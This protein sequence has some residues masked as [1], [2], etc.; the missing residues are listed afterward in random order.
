MNETRGEVVRALAAEMFGTFALV[1]AGTGAIVVNARTGGTLGSVGIA[2]TF[3]FVIMAMIYATGHIS[4]AHFNPAVT[5]GFAI[6]RQFPIWLVLPYWGAQVLGAV[7]GSLAVYFLIGSEGG[8]GTTHPANGVVP[9]LLLEGL[10]TLILMFV[11]MAVAT[12]TRAIGE[13]AAIA[14][15]GT[16]AL[17]ALFAGAITGASMNPARSLGPA[18][19][20]N[21]FSDLALYI[22]GP[23]FG[24]LLGSALYR[25]MGAHPKS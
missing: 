22:I 23:I 19:V 14:I 11:I 2:L 17:E 15:G 21:N 25:W 18:L 12:D 24:A 5:L 16:I 13:A 9:A 6:A 10:L 4:G 8:L 1:L 20:S 3:G 7:L